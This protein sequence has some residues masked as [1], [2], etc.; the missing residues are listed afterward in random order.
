[1]SRSNGTYTAPTS[2]WKPA[3][4]G[5]VIDSSDWN[6]L[7]DDVEAAVTE[8]VYTGG[9]GA[10]DNAMARTD[11]TD[12]KKAQGSPPTISDTGIIAGVATFLLTSYTIGTLPAG[13]E[14]QIAYASDWD[15]N[16]GASTGSLVFHDGE[17]W[18]GV[19]TGATT[20]QVPEN[21]V[22]P[23]ISGTTTVGQTLSTT[24]GTWLY[25]PTSYTY[26]WKRDGVSI[27]SATNSTYLLA[28]ADGGTAITVE[29]VA[30]NVAGASAAAASTATALV[31]EIPSNDVLPVISGTP[32]VGETLSTTNGT[33]D[34]YP[35]PTY[36]YQWKRDGVSIGGAT[37][38]TYLLVSA[39]SST[40]VTVTVTATNAAGATSATS[41]A[42]EVVGDPSF[43]SVSLLLGGN[44]ADAAT[45]TTDESASAHT[46]TFNGNAQLD[47]AQ[48]KFGTASYL[49]D[50]TGDYLS[51]PSATN[52]QLPEEFTVELWARFNTVA[53]CCFI[54]KWDG[55]DNE[56][57]MTFGAGAIFFWV[58][59]G[60]INVNATGSFSPSTGVWY[61]LAADRDAAGTLRVYVDGVMAG[62]LLSANTSRTGDD[63]VEIGRVTTTLFDGWIDEVRV[64]KGV[65]RYASDS[66]Y[67]VPAA[68]F[69]RS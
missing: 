53:T 67:T 38:A 17:A 9:L 50:G 68:E 58:G 55:T 15:K 21:T 64:T 44:G 27:G 63:P 28:D 24:T 33:W 49:F 56:W 69:P 51:I 20:G 34:G 5:S 11:G 30:N 16:G 2:G 39:D 8:T 12:T 52:L 6:T 4:E 59:I 60:G 65:A 14:G 7:L 32:E 31:H 18:R 37:N 40:D 43:S 10:T 23:V 62:K 29:V 47:T 48:K 36:T 45:T 46:V 35:V 57:M 41:A 19:D 22:V 26:Q 1:M 13:A 61:H 54:S 25:S 3:L 66:G 42:V